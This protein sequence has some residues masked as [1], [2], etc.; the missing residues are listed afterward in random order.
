MSL[1]VSGLR[2]LAH[3]VRLRIL[4]LLTGASMSAADIARELDITQANASYHLRQ[5]AAVGVVVDA[6]ERKIRGGSAKLYRHPVGGPPTK[7]TGDDGSHQLYIQ[8]FA[9]EMVRRYALHVSGLPGQAT[10]T[11]AELWVHP[12]VW[13]DLVTATGEASKRLHDAAQPP[14]TDG[15]VRVSMTAALFRMRP[16]DPQPGAES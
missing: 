14:R 10:Y 5:L 2:A 3:P 11:D 7:L 1:E 8:A 15:T 16:D 13:R 12:D 9:T 6:G 4:S